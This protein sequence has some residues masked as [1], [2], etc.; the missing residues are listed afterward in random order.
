MAAVDDGRGHLLRLGRGQHE[1][2][3]RG[4]LLER[5]EEGVPRRRGQH[6]RL[7]E[8]VD[9]VT[10]GDGGVGDALAQLADVVDRVVGGGVHLDDIERHRRSDRAT[11]VAHAARRD[12]RALL[13]VQAGGEDLRHRGLARAAG[14]DEQVRVVHAAALHG[15]AQRAYD[16]FLP[17]DV[18]K[19]T[20]TMATVQRGRAGHRTV[21]VA[22]AAAATIRSPQPV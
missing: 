20:G 8:D 22:V 16:E 3:V 18:V 19:R 7:V 5:L 9:L 12:R 13:A 15:V 14:A 6:V 4:R 21:S 11:R 10:P 2:R 17:D 1:H